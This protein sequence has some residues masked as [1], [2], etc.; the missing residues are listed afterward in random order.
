[1]D[2]AVNVVVVPVAGLI[3]PSAVLVSAHAYVMPDGQVPLHV[4]VAVKTFPLPALTV[5]DVGVRA[6]EESVTGP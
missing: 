5:G 3:E 1:M 2:P 4:G 6:T